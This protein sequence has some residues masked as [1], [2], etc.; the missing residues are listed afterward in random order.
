M[1]CHI[2]NYLLITTSGYFTSIIQLLRW[3]LTTSALL[4]IVQIRLI[5]MKSVN[6]ES[7]P[8]G[9][10]MEFSPSAGQLLLLLL[11]SLPPKK[12]TIRCKSPPIR[13]E[14][15]FSTVI[16]Q[17][18]WRRNRCIDWRIIPPARNYVRSPHGNSIEPCSPNFINYHCPTAT[19]LSAVSK[20]MRQRR[21]QP[22]K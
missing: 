19:K 7:F 12:E 2:R 5:P 9:F 20:L 4:Q 1:Y 22:E 14:G 16:S 11:N 18:T 10:L 21:Y 8:I 15:F 3:Q 17:P 13:S 6:S